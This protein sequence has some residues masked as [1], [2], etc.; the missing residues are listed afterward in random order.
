MIPKTKPKPKPKPTVTPLAQLRNVKLTGA[1]LASVI[2]ITPQSLSTAYQQ[3]RI[4]R[5]ADGTYSLLDAV[6]AYIEDLRRQARRTESD[7]PRA[8]YDY[9]RTELT[10]TKV[11]SWVE[12]RD[13]E[14]AALLASAVAPILRDIGE[15][16]REAAPGRYAEGLALLE[17]LEEAGIP[18]IITPPVEDGEDDAED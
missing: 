1:A 12:Q 13:Q 4:P 14:V 7:D 17:K 9:W 11:S 8:E 18:G 2:G 10:K 15:V 5:R 16:I 3:G 6:K